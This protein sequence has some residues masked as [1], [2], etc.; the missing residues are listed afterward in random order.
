MFDAVLQSVP[1]SC[2]D[3]LGMCID[4]AASKKRKRFATADDADES[5]SD[6]AE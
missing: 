2:V 6:Y 5:S 3:M 4:S 1:V